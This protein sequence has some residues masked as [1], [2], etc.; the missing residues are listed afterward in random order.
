MRLDGAGCLQDDDGAAQVGACSSTYATPWCERG[1]G[2]WGLLAVAPDAQGSGVASALV[3]VM[4]AP[5][6]ID[7]RRR[8]RRLA[9]RTPSPQ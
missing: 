3:Q 9:L 6:P 2:H 1:C 8:L 4:L 5:L 7:A